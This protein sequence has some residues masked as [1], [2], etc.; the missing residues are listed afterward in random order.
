MNITLIQSLNIDRDTSWDPDII[1][2]GSHLRWRSIQ[3]GSDYR[4][5]PVFQWSIWPRTGHLKTEPFE[6]PKCCFLIW[7]CDYLSSCAW[8][9]T[10][11]SSSEVGYIPFLDETMCEQAS[12]HW[13]ECQLRT[14]SYVNGICNWWS[15]F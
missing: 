8:R 9:I 11:W 4:T 5:S 7:F 3:W 15:K 10:N 1:I 2:W 14:I 6:Y 12:T 13:P